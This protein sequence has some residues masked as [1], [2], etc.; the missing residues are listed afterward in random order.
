MR[1]S[2]IE[3]ERIKELSIKVFG[4]GTKVFL[5]GSRVDDR[6]K[7]GDIDLLISN[8]NK[9]KLTISAKVL[10]LEELKRII[11]DQKIDIEFDSNSF[12]TKSLFYKTI[13]R[14]A[15]EL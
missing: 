9:E 8:T 13:K 4:A 15:L 2:A 6:I 7:G 10:Y 1:I 5:Y 11:G 3:I 14:E 12:K